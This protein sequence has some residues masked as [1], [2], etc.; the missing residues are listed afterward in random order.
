M[1]D[2]GRA[3]TGAEG[4]KVTNREKMLN[5]MSN[6]ELID[7]LELTRQCPHGMPCEFATC[8]E[9]WERFLEEEADED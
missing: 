9:C 3:R 5:A 7:E 6:A 2:K 4:E 8:E 1:L